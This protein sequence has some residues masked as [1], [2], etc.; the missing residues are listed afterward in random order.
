MNNTGFTKFWIEIIGGVIV[1]VVILLIV[2]YFGTSI[3][4]GLE[5][6]AVAGI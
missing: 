5:D 1:V 2:V 6:A 3:A 4:T